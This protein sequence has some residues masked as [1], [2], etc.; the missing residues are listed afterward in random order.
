MTRPA[1]SSR[2]RVLIAFARQEPDRVPID[3]SANAGT[4]ARLKTHLG[5]APTCGIINYGDG[6]HWTEAETHGA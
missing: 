1:L 2:E 5:P 6:V 4:D 3:H